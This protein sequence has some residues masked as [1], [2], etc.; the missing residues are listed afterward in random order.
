MPDAG[1]LERRVNEAKSPKSRNDL[2]PLEEERAVIERLQA[3]DRTA[4]AT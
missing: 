3:G 4:F 1:A 2:V